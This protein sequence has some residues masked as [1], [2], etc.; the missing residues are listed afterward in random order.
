MKRICIGRIAGAHGIKGQV[1][2]FPLCEDL[3]LLERK[4]GITLEDGTGI[5]L[6]ISGTTG[7]KFLLAR[8]KD[9][10]DRNSAETLKGKDLFLPREALPPSGPEDGHYYSDL[11]DLR[12]ID[13][14]GA[15]AGTVIDI[16][17]FGAGDL[18]EI[19]PPDGGP[20]FYL[21][22]AETESVDLDAGTVTVSRAALEMFSGKDDNNDT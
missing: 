17:D 19:R 5:T 18:L 3:G 11:K 13:E 9:V 6:T 16:A 12:L 8:I 15:Q 2:I 14:T 7:G 20:S 1:K 22:Y 4:S 21:P 10:A